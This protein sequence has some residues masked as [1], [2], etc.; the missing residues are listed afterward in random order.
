[1]ADSAS[2]QTVEPGSPTK[3]SDVLEMHFTVAEIADKWKLSHVKVQHIFQDEPGVLKLGHPSRLVGRNL[4]RR[5]YTLRIPE[6]V[7]L[8]VQNRLMHK[9][10]SESVGL[11]IARRGGGRL[12]PS[13]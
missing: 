6:S 13:S 5:Y 4:Q 7:F 9:R 3:S 8:R 1:M 10:D 11:P 2:F 12:R